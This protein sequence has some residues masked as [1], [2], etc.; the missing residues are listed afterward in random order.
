MEEIGD[1]PKNRCGSTFVII[2]LAK[3]THTW[4]L[5][6]STSDRWLEFISPSSTSGSFRLHVLQQFLKKTAGFGGGDEPT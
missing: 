4:G 1:G 5:V 3:L 6:F 2:F